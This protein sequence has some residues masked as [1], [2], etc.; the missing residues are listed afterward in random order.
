MLGV[1]REGVTE[2]ARKLQKL[3]LVHCGGGHI[4]VIDRAGLEARCCEC[5]DVV[6]RE[7]DRLLPTVRPPAAVAPRLNSLVL[8]GGR[9]ES[10]RTHFSAGACSRACARY[11]RVKSTARLITQRDLLSPQLEMI[12]IV[13][14]ESCGTH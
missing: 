6:S 14:S 8:R 3:G 7:F 4:A 12:E 9:V 11:S 13:G 2:A 5:Y 1:R 10:G